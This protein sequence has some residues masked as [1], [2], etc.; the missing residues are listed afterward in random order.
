MRKTLLVLTL[1]SLSLA[2]TPTRVPIK[3][4]AGK[5]E[6]TNESLKAALEPYLDRLAAEDKFSGAVMITKDGV[7]I[8][9]K[10]YGLAS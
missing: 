10:A 5:L 3:I 2:A 7:P 8:F 4:R 6:V 1:A 9:R